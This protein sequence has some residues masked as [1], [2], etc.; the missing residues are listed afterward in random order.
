ME[1][2]AHPERIQAERERTQAERKKAE[3]N[4]AQN[5]GGDGEP[6]ADEPEQE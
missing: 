4:Q 1:L 6:S 5:P 2:A 3:Q